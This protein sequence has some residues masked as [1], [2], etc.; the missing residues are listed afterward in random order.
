[1][2]SNDR[3]LR[4]IDHQAVSAAGGFHFRGVNFETTYCCKRQY[5]PANERR[6]PPPPAGRDA[7]R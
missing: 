4:R 1:V 3:E 7:G 5:R 6:H 2:Q